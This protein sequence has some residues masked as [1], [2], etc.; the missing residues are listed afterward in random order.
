MQFA[1]INAILLEGKR[2]MMEDSA[3]N[4]VKRGSLRT[5]NERRVIQRESPFVMQIASLSDA[6]LWHC[7]TDKQ[8]KLSIE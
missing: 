3:F 6:I 7:V 8:L 5:G 1:K 2:V 4:G